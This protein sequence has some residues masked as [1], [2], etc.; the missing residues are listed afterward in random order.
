MKFVSFVQIAFRFLGLG[1]SL[2]S[3]TCK[4]S[5]WEKKKEQLQTPSDPPQTEYPTFIPISITIVEKGVVKAPSLLVDCD[6]EVGM[7]EGKRRVKRS[8]ER[9]SIVGA[10]TSAAF[11]YTR[12]QVKGLGIIESSHFYTIQEGSNDNGCYSFQVLERDCKM[13][14]WR[15]KRKKVKITILCSS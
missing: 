4:K 5:K 6:V 1:G 11:S 15:I 3:K 12:G 13:R 9:G 14:S 8:L 10:I 2:D 7:L